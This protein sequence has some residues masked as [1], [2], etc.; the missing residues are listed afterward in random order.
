MSETFYIRK[1]KN[2]MKFCFK[3]EDICMRRFFGWALNRGLL[4]LSYFQ[5]F[6]VSDWESVKDYLRVAG[7]DVKVV[8]KL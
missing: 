6:T 1:L 8:S 4:D 7:P 3:P 5:T 2:G